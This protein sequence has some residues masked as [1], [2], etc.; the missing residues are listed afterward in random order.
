MH[1]AEASQNIDLREKQMEQH[2]DLKERK[3]GGIRRTERIISPAR[4]VG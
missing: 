1:A 4:E 3:A 2:I